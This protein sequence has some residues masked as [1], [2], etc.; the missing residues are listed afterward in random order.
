MC[1]EWHQEHNNNICYIYLH[2][3]VQSYIQQNGYL[4]M[5]FAVSSLQTNTGIHYDPTQK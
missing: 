2:V 4:Y 5:T 3:S 1:M